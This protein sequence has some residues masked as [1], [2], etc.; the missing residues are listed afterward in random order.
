MRGRN[1]IRTLLVG[2]GYWGRILAENLLAHPTYFLAGVQDTDA[3]VVLEARAK[4][5]HAYSSLE[6]AMQATHPQLVVIAAPIGRMEMPATRALQAY[7]HVMMAKP[8]VVSIDSY[9]RLTRLAEY[10]QRTVCIDYTML[11]ASSWATI[12]NEQHKLG[13]VTK[14]HSVR[15]AVGN[16]TGAPILDDM[17]VHDL[18]MLADLDPDREWLIDSASMTSTRVSARFVSGDAVALL[19]ADT[20]SEKPQRSVYLGGSG[21]WLVWDQL[22]DV[23]ESSDASIMQSWY[24]DEK[25]PC[26]PVQ[27]R[28]NMMVNVVNQRCDDNRI[29]ARKV[30]ALREQIVEAA[31]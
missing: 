1:L 20:E 12:L 17:L 10:V 21:A 13:R 11:A 24:E 14:F 26:T 4:N 8:G 29:V 22:Q 15:S 18:A 30:L 28:L 25:I 5:L 19:E 31:R 27:R 16:R 6:D 23:I 9:D 7:A 3:S 2:Y